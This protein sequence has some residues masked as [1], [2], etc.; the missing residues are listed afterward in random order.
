[1]KAYKVI[2]HYV[3]M[4]ENIIPVKEMTE[5]L[6]QNDLKGMGVEYKLHGLIDENNREKLRTRDFE[7][8]SYELIEKN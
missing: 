7:M 6:K 2:S 8:V 3:V 5:M 1:M 4:Q